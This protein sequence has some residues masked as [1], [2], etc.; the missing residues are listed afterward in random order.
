M[1]ET[2]VGRPPGSETFRQ[3]LRDRG[4]VVAARGREAGFYEH[5][6]TLGAAREGVLREPLQEVL[7]D[8]YGVV[9]GEVRAHDDS[10]SGQWDVL[11]YNRLETPRMYLSP[12]AAVLPIEGVLAAISVKSKL[13]KRAIYEVAEAAARLRAMSRKSLPPKPRSRGLAPAVFAFGFQGIAL[14]RLLRHTHAATEGPE[15]P[16]RLTGV[17]VLG[18]G[19]VLPINQQSNVAPEDIQGYNIA[20]ASEGAWGM[21][22]G[23]LSAALIFQP[24]AAPNLLSHIGLGELLDEQWR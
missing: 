15:S 4:V 2:N 20:Y 24:H 14:P 16:R 21:F 10:V 8:R 7:P 17:C 19:L 13:D 11:I 1:S 6:P 5:G 22:V 18:H 23:I 9:S 12:G 3:L